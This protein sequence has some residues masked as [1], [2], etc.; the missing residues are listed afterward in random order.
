MRQGE[1]ARQ[2]ERAR[3][4]ERKQSTGIERTILM[5]RH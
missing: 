4:K 5:T 2:R 1:R 3:K